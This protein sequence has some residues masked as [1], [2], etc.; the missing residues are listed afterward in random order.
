MPTSIGIPKWDARYCSYL[1]LIRRKGSLLWGRSRSNRQHGLKTQSSVFF[2]NPQRWGRP[3]RE[4][5]HVLKWALKYPHEQS[6]ISQALNLITCV[7]RSTYSFHILS[8]ANLCLDLKKPSAPGKR[9]T[10]TGKRNSVCVRVRACVLNNNAVSSLQN[11][12]HR[13]KYEHSKARVHKF[14]EPCCPG[15][16]TCVW[17]RQIF[18]GPQFL[19]CFMSPFRS[20]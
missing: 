7:S 9:V 13:H 18:V 20:L 16:I 6:W 8:H 1:R 19:S 4:V 10:F 12:Q 11:W 5:L 15:R 3:L 14:W 17:W 2:W